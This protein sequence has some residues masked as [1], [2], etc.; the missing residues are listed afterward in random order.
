MSPGQ[1]LRPGRG[2]F[3]ISTLVLEEKLEYNI[4]LPTLL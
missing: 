3:S 1:E 2:L 4:F